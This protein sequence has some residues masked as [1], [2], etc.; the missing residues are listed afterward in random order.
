MAK[1]R[2]Q[3]KQLEKTPFRGLKGLSQSSTTPHLWVPR[4]S[5]GITTETQSEKKNHR[6]GGKKGKP[7]LKEGGT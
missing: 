4:G 3:I 7:E 6:S 2:L 5:G 1:G